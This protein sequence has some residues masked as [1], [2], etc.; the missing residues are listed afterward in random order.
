MVLDFRQL[1]AVNVLKRD[2]R[3]EEERIEAEERRKNVE[4]SMLPPPLPHPLPDGLADGIQT[5]IE[6]TRNSPVSTIPGR[7]PSAI[8]IS[9]LHRPQFPLKLDLS[10]PS[11]RITEEEAALY[12]KGLASPVTLAPKSARPMDTAE[13]SGELMAAFATASVPLEVGHN[14]GN[15]ALTLPKIHNQPSM[16]TLDV[17]AGDSSDK[18]IELDMDAMDM[19]M[20][21]LTDQ[22][23]VPSDPGESSNIH[24]GLFSPLEDDIEAQQLQ[25][26][27]HL[28][29]NK[30]EENALFQ[31]D[32]NVD[33]ELFGNFTSTGDLEVDL[34]APAGTMPQ[35]QT[36]SIPSP[37]SLLAQ[38]SS[39]GVM[40]VKPSSPTGNP[41]IH[42]PVASFDLGPIDLT[43]DHNFFSNSQDG[44]I[45]LSMEM[46]SFMNSGNGSSVGHGVEESG[47][48]TDKG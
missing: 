37:G 27:N 38:L 42:D 18:P 10:S 39:S 36:T 30:N 19:D 16:S 33:D 23:G 11:L 2:L 31:I 13:F 24:D 22:F 29:S 21:N 41:S 34:N 43:L 17:G 4:V 8:S 5:T 3:R 40:D 35:H 15:M 46:T 48:S 25:T 20:A 26:H 1:R 7:R 44:E 9:S 47:P 12:S 32:S 6:T 28:Q 14:T 45:G